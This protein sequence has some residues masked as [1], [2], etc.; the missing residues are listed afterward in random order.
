MPQY[1]QVRLLQY[2]IQLTFCPLALVRI[3]STVWNSQ[4]VATKNYKSSYSHSS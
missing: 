1:T 4:Q 3:V 2:E